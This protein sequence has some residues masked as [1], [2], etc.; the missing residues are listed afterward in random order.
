MKTR[1]LYKKLTMLG[2]LAGLAALAGCASLAP[3]KLT[4][5]EAKMPV[6]QVSDIGHLPHYFHKIKYIYGESNGI[7][8]A[9]SKGN[10]G[11]PDAVRDAY[12][13]HADALVLTFVGQIP[14]HLGQAALGYAIKW[15]PATEANLR[16]DLQNFPHLWKYQGQALLRW[17]RVKHMSNLAPLV[18]ANYKLPRLIPKARADLLHTLGAIAG[19]KYDG[20][21]LAWI[22]AGDDPTINA[23]LLL[24]YGTRAYVPEWKK[25]LFYDSNAMVRETAADA[26]M[27]YHQRAS[28]RQALGTEKSPAVR[29]HLKQLLLG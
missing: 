20:Q 21:Y 26:L 15:V 7:T 18:V 29:Q 12:A 16:A 23:G 25:L 9:F 10:P 5:A 19:A 17:I 14:T 27:R 24:K 28:V 13:A 6:Y 22:K 4:P 3:E 8:D 11:V 2:L 1:A